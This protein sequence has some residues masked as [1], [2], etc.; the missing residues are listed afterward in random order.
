LWWLDVGT[1]GTT[2]VFQDSQWI[3][4]GVRFSADGQWIS[5]IAPQT[6]AIQVYN[7][8]TGENITIES[9]TGEPPSWRPI[10]TSLLGTKVQLDGDNFAIHI[11]HINTAN[12][13]TINLSGER[14]VNDSWPVFSPDGKWVAF[15]R[16]TPQASAG[17][18]VWLMGADGTKVVNLTNRDEIHFGAPAW[19]ADGRFLTFQGYSLT[20]SD[21][22]GIWLYDLDNQTLQLITTPGIRPA[23]LP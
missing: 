6:Q 7:L 14:A 19:S 22:P 21:Q 9:Q 10:D 8:Q 11:I 18:Q 16:K 2:A 15:T 1:G 17:K 12:H 5:Y 13:E 4:L 23:W 20:E 3:G